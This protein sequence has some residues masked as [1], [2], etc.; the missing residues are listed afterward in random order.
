M[1]SEFM[2]NRQLIAQGLKAP[3]AKKS[4]AAKKAA[5]ME[6]DGDITLDEWFLDRRKEMTGK[7]AHCGGPYCKHDNMFFKHSIAHLLPKKPTMF[8]SVKTHPENWIELCFWGNNCHGNLDAG[9]LDLIELNCFDQVIEKFVR[10]YPS[11]E[12]KER[13]NIPAVLLQYAKD[14]A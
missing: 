10:M 1:L 13:R 9:T 14:N 12:K 8:P 11:I 6:E 5:K 7:C 3:E 4:P 2:R